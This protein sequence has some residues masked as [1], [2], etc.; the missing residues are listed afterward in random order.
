MKKLLF[1]IA[2]AFVTLQLQAQKFVYGDLRVTGSTYVTG[3]IQSGN[4][5]TV[6]YMA[7]DSVSTAKVKIGSQR[8]TYAA[9]DSLVDNSY[10]NRSYTAAL[11]DSLPTA[12]EITAVAGTP[13]SRGAGYKAVIKDTNGSSLYYLVISTGTAWYYFR[14]VL[15]L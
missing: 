14:G 5:L 13:A 10:V 6:P 2:I 8:V 9:G 4:T 3:S 12:A 15:A 7:V 1:L 11:T